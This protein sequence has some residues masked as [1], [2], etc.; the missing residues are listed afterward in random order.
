MAEMQEK[1]CQECGRPVFGRV[2]KKFCSDGCRNA[3]NNKLN[4]DHVNLVRRVN[5]ILRKNRR[6]LEALNPEGK[7]KTHRE[8]L[9]KQGFN[10]EYFTNRYTNKKGDEYLFCYDQGFLELEKG[11]VLLVKRNQN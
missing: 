3:F 2:D 1:V 6:I 5:N 8:E 9:L 10:F 11:F 7:K 4:A